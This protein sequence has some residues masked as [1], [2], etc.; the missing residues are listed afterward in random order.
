MFLFIMLF[1]CFSLSHWLHLKN[2][3][4]CHVNSEVFCEIAPLFIRF[5]AAVALERFQPGVRPRVA[6]QL[7]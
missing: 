6:L 1:L 7:T 4:L 2:C 5:V 3:L